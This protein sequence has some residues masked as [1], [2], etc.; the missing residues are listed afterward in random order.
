MVDISHAI[1]T[2]G[3]MSV[4]ELTYLAEAASKSNIIVEVG[5][6]KGRSTI[7]LAANTPGRVIAVDSF[8]GDPNYAPHAEEIESNG[9]WEWLYDEFQR[10]LKSAGVAEKVYPIIGNSVK[11]ATSTYT[12]FD[13]IFID[14][15]HDYESVKDDIIAWKPLLREGGILCGHDFNEDNWP[16]VVKAVREL[17]PVFRVVPGTTIWTTEI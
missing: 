12:K 5:S 9:G 6:W 2:P 13:M 17:I 14:A 4:E 3:W 15:S 16:G 1:N 8:L 11:V 7:A 10:N